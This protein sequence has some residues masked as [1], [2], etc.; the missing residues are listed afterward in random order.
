VANESFPFGGENIQIVKEYEYLGV[1]FSNSCL[2]RKAA[3][4]AKKKGLGAV[5][6]L[7][8]LFTTGRVNSWETHRK[9]F[10]TI[11]STAFL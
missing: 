4:S 9:L 5:D 6:S 1:K 8:N 7:W 3:D 10:N 2:F 11:V